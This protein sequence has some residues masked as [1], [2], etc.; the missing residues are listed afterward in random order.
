VGKQQIQLLKTKM[1]KEK[2]VKE[3]TTVAPKKAKTKKHRLKFRKPK[4]TN[5]MIITMIYLFRVLVIVF[6][7]VYPVLIACTAAFDDGAKNFMLYA[8]YSLPQN[9]VKFL[10]FNSQSSA[11]GAVRVIPLLIWLVFALMVFL[12]YFLPFILSKHKGAKGFLAFYYMLFAAIGYGLIYGAHFWLI[13]QLPHGDT[14]LDPVIMDQKTMYWIELKNTFSYTSFWMIGQ[15]IFHGITFVFG[16]WCAIES[17]LIRKKKLS[18]DDLVTNFDRENTLANKILNG[19]LEFGNV[20]DENLKLSIMKL[21]NKLNIEA[22]MVEEK[23][24]YKD[25]EVEEDPP[26]EAAT[27]A[28][29]PDDKTDHK[30]AT[31]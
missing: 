24:V 16:V 2:T 7:A 27:T 20:A 31:V 19:Q 21:K 26:D 1:K 8:L 9:F 25:E 28:V 18:Y 6:V 22:A 5:P 10:T 3:V 12:M 23:V 13:D 17:I 29:P 4:T 14:G 30:E 15:Q 11:E